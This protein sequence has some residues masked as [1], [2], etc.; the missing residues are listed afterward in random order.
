MEYPD[1]FAE[2]VRKE[3]PG[4]ET[5]RMLKGGNPFLGRILDD[6]SQGGISPQAVIEFLD[7]GDVDG[8]RAV[9]TTR[10]RRKELY[11]EWG[12]LYQQEHVPV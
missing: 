6:S 10:V 1:D 9:A 5:E 4:E 2:R 7:A 3:Y 12:R 11:A 8:L